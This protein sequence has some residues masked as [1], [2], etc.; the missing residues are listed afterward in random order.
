LPITRDPTQLTINQQLQ[1]LDKYEWNK[2]RLLL[3]PWKDHLGGSTPADIF[4]KPGLLSMFLEQ[5]L[6]PDGGNIE[7]VNF[8]ERQFP[9]F[10]LSSLRTAPVNIYSGKI[11]KGFLP[12]IPLR[13]PTIIIIIVIIKPGG[14]P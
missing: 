3:E 2:I 12:L 11:T 8:S 7:R 9:P 5:T 6:L 13:T 10:A 4:L 1:W 14:S